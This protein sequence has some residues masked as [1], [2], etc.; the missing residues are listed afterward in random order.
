MG[1][2]GEGMMTTLEA[3]QAKAQYDSL[4]RTGTGSRFIKIYTSTARIPFGKP[5]RKK[6]PTIRRKVIPMEWRKAA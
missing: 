6:K 1:S 5:W 3:R 4:R 2:K